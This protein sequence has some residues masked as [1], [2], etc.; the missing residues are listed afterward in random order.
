M[1]RIF[2]VACI[3]LI[4]AGFL[5]GCKTTST[6]G[7]TDQVNW[8]LTNPKTSAIAFHP[9][10][11]TGP[12]KIA[13][14]RLT[15]ITDRKSRTNFMQHRLKLHHGSHYLSYLYAKLHPGLGWGGQ[16]D[17]R[18]WTTKYKDGPATILEKG[19]TSYNGGVAD[20]VIIE[21]PSSKCTRFRANI[22]VTGVDNSSQPY[23]TSV[24]DGLYCGPK[25][26]EIDVSV[27]DEIIAG[28]SVAE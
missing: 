16:P 24:L 12:R 9:E 11:L 25:T 13:F 21:T 8:I 19:K 22:G 5:T 1:R 2:Q 6:V 4:G 15:P 18:K 26:E 23:G 10:R 17:L 28:V 20:Y 27:V 7:T 14:G 3:L